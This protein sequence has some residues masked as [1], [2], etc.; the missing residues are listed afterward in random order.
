MTVTFYKNKSDKIVVDKNLTQVGSTIT[1]AVIKEDIS[2]IGEY[3]VMDELRKDV[4][5]VEL[6]NEEAGEETWYYVL[7]SG[8]CPWC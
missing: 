7:Y 1:S 8:K 6:W 5:L 2:I 3:Y 4:G